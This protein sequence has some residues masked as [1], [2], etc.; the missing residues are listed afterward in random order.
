MQLSDFK[1]YVKQDF[2]RTDKD[3]ELIRARNDSILY[4]AVLLPPHAGYKY[5]SYVP[6]V[7]G[8]TNYPLPSDLIHLIHPVRLLKGSGT[9]DSAYPLDHL[10][11][12]EY[13]DY[14]SNPNRTSPSTGQ[15]MRY[16]VFSRA[17]LPSPIPDKDTYFFEI[18]WSKRPVDQT[19]DASLH[20]LGSEWDE[21]LKWM[22]LARLN[23]GIE[24]FQEMQ[25]WESKYQDSDGN[26]I[27]MLKR[28]L[29]I[30]REREYKAIGQV[31]PN[32]L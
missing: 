5:Q 2:K 29:D 22:V 17:I 21:V 6:T 20:S 10:T 9:N 32:D 11:K 7:T 4:I 26:P 30:E 15:P 19:A 31:R 18:D 14:E 24:L 8:Q 13:D 3:T 12:Q 25:V 1:T 16:C 28:L 27:G 23:A